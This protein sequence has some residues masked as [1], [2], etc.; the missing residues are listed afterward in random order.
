[1]LEE[2]FSEAEKRTIK[3]LSY[4]R[5]GKVSVISAGPL[6]TLKIVDFE[7]LMERWYSPQ[8]EDAHRPCRC[9][10]MCQD[11]DSLYLVEFKTGSATALSLHRK[12][13]DSLNGLVENAGYSFQEARQAVV[14]LVVKGI[15]GVSPK[16]LLEGR[17]EERMAEPWRSEK[18]KCEYELYKQVGVWVRECYCLN[19]T[20]FE[21]YAQRFWGNTVHCGL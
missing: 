17:N 11:G 1:M 5:E 2:L 15:Q 18:Y 8:A 13:Y 3:E 4:N 20:Q 9:D 12:L 7:R 14:Y 10:G 16:D 6:A 21:T 19:P